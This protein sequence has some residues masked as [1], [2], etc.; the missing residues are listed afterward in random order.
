MIQQSPNISPKKPS[1]KM[2]WW[3]KWGGLFFT[4]FLLMFCI[5]GIILNHRKAFSPFDIPRS[6]LPKAYH[7]DHW[8]IGA[9]KGG[10]Q[11]NSDSVLFF[12]SNGI[13]L[14]SSKAENYIP[15]NEGLK[16]GADN[17]LII[18]IIKTNNNTIIACANFDIYQLDIKKKQWISLSEYL[19]IDERITDIASE[20]NN[21]IVQTRSH[22][23]VAA[24]PF[25]SFK[26]VTIKAP[27][28]EKIQNGL[29]RTIWT[30]HSGE[31]FGLIG[32]LFVD[33]LG[34]VVIIL[35]I[36]GLVITFS[37]KLIS[38]NKKNP[39]RVQKGR[40][41]FNLAMKWHNKIGVT[42]LVF[43]LIL[44]I[45]GTFL[46][47]PLLIPI[48]RVK[49]SPIPFTTQYTS[50]TWNDKLR[51][52]RYDN[53]NKQWL[54]YTSEG[55]FQLKTLYDSP[56]RLSSAPPV[57]YMGVTVLEQQDANRWVVGSF[58]GLFEWNTQTG[59]IQDLYSGEP[60][61]SVSADGIPTSTNSVACY[62]KPKDKEAI[63]FDY[64]RGAE[65]TNLEPTFIRMPQSFHQARMSLWHVALETHAG[66]IYSF[67]P[68]IIVK[69]FIFLSGVF[70]ISVLISGYVAYR[71]IH[72]KKSSRKE[73]QNK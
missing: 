62:Y 19:P 41:G 44:A 45:T 52:I 13:G 49:H 33:L 56:K 31:L 72:K 36:T 23:Y 48:V 57:S 15:F 22:L 26:Q 21:L 73:I 54:I 2:R 69:L 53:V 18:N 71:K 11:L 25:T 43:L 34:V 51:T 24:Y 47:P 30:L 40:K 8:N 10:I 27:N 7:Y 65:N 46:R 50:N 39:N 32:K 1:K 42:I 55:F 28:D 64:G 58:R 70:L 60:F 17:R 66:R 38:L 37:P 9:V 20:G 61:Y 68:Q 12:G 35:C 14:Y 63:V 29:F 16:N 3:H 4:F 6:I 5:S 59:A 67:L